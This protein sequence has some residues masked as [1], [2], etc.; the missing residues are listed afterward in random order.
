MQ[1]RKIIPLLVIVLLIAAVS[2][3]SAATYNKPVNQADDRVSG[4]YQGVAKSA[5][6]GDIPLTVE[7]KNTEGKLSGQI[8]TPQGPAP[9]TGGTFADGKL[10]MKFDA[11]GTEGT[12]TAMLKENV[13]TGDW[14]LGGQTGTLELKRS[15]MGEMAKKEEMKPMMGDPISGEWDATADAQGQSIPFTLTLK[16]DGEKVTGQSSGQAGDATINSGSWKA[17]VLTISLD[18]PN[19]PIVLTAKLTDGKLVGE[20]DFASQFKGPWEAKKK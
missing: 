20:Y 1:F 12:V 18:T 16:L 10:M 9:I 2:A 13:I 3:V 19:G 5:Q 6:M 7:I 4:K 8:E 15:D 17:D 14:E 11:G